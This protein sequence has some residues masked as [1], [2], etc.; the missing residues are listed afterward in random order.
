M[1]ASDAI[2]ATAAA[3]FT[4]LSPPFK[5]Q[6]GSIQTIFKITVNGKDLA[7][8]T[9]NKD[10]IKCSEPKGRRLHEAEPA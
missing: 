2:K 7:I 8:L 1:D 5:V 3:I 10:G 4:E 9:I 6:I